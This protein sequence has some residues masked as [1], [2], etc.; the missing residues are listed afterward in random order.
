MI[1]VYSRLLFSSC[2][3]YTWPSAHNYCMYNTIN[4]HTCKSDLRLINRC[5]QSSRTE[6]NFITGTHAKA[7]KAPIKA[8][9][10]NFIRYLNVLEVWAALSTYIHLLQSLQSRWN[11]VMGKIQPL[12]E[13]CYLGGI[14]WPYQRCRMREQY[15][16][17]TDLLLRFS[18]WRILIPYKKDFI[19]H[20]TLQNWSPR[21]IR[22]L[23]CMSF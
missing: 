15:N 5:W 20:H 10:W 21:A 2:F 17:W 8:P 6:D 16:R 12:L 23:Y 13:K 18:Y 7:N 3:V 9:I 22:Y 11:I 1:R 4:C 14:S 19:L